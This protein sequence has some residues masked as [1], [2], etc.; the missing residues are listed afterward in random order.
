MS[1]SA[2]RFLCLAATVAGVFCG[3]AYLSGEENSTGDQAAGAV[4]EALQREIYGLKAEREELLS[5][6]TQQAPRHAPAWWHQGYVQ[7]GKQG[8]TNHASFL[9][10]AN[11]AERLA[12][13]EKQR[14]RASDTIEGQLELADWCAKHR[15]LGQERAHLTRV[16][17]LAPEHPVAR[18]RLGFVQQGGV[19]ISGQ[20]IARQQSQVA[21]RQ[22]ALREWLP[23]LRE[24]RLGLEHRSPQRRS[25]AV[26]KL[27]DMRDAAAVP[28]I[29]EVFAGAADEVQIAGLGAL[30]NISD[31]TA[32]LAIAH[33]AALG[34][35]Q[36]VR[37]EAVEALS[38]R[39]LDSFVPQ[40][41][42]SLSSP[43]VSRFMATTLPTGRIGYRHVF[44]RE[45]QEQVNIV[46]LDTEFRRIPL[47]GGNRR[48]TTSR[49]FAQAG[50]MARQREEQLAAQN[51]Q[52]AAMNERLMWVLQNATGEQLPAAPEA[53]WQWWNDRNEVFIAG[54]KPQTVS[55][56]VERIAVQDNVPDLSSGSVAQSVTPPS[57]PRRSDCLAAGTP[58][59]TIKG[60][61]AIETIRVGDLVLSQHPD[62]GELTYKPVLRTTLRP[63]GELICIEAG[64]ELYQTSGGH[65]FWV[66]GEGWVK[67]RDLVS[68]QVLHS[69][70]GPVHI[71]SVSSGIEAQTYN[72]IVAD[73]ATYFVG[74]QRVLSHD[75]SVRTPTRALVPGLLAQ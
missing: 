46:A 19:W 51:R 26:A 33:A 7:D 29:E 8:W 73:F 22:A 63:P 1:A 17:D 6:A 35:S 71:T 48:E 30:E 10:T 52:I 4:R 41:L 40:L 47:I 57:P 66:A 59:W 37:N 67:S 43:I 38:K 75:N 31:P 25:H 12:A 34:S 20:E 49:A 32:S 62:T 69:V 58:V 44:A 70:N 60:P 68:G 5:S 56:Q 13:Y 28:A 9:A 24:V 42:A 23:K 45:G 50:D 39:D 14:D 16:I 53:W 72:L 54:T 36:N 3:G 64:G 15:L 55:Y 11:R 27:T 61:Q 21:A 18:A 65:L 74:Q 2:Y